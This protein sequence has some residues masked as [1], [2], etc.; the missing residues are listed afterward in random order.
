MLHH[1]PIRPAALAAL[2]LSAVPA[3]SSAGD[4]PDDTTIEQVVVIAHKDQRSIRDVA[5]NVTTLSRGELN[6]ELATSIGDAFRYVPGVDYEGAGTR[7]GTEGINIRGIGG[8]RVAILVDGVPLAD[9]FDTGSFSNATRDFIDAG[10]IQDIEVLHGPASAL[11]GSSAIGGVVAVRTPDPSDIARGGAFGGE[12]LGTWNGK[13]DSAHGQVMAAHGDDSFGFLAGYSRRS[14]EQTDS[15]A[16]PSDVDT[17][18]Y[19]RE[20]TLLKFVSDNR[21]GHTIRASAV[22]QDGHT[23]SNLNSVLGAGRYRSTTALEGD[24]HQRMDVVTLAYEFGSPESWIDSGVLRTFWQQTEI[25]QYTLDQRAA[26]RT[27]V[28]IDRRFSYDQEIRGIEMNLWKNITGEH[29]THRVGMG[30]E[31]RDRRTTEFRDGLST[32]LATGDQTNVLLGEVFPLR[33]FPISDTKQIAAFFEDTMSIGEKWTVIAAMRA[34]RYELSPHIDAMYLADYPDYETTHLD[35]SDISPKLGVIYSI[36]PRIDAYVQYSHGFRAPPYSDANVSLELPIFRVRAVPNPELESESSDGFDIGLRWYGLRSTA[37]V[38]AF[39]TNYTN[40]IET[41]VNIGI[42][43]VSG[44]TQFQ[45]QNIEDTT[46]E[47]IEAGW[48]VRFGDLEQ[49]MLDGSA[50]YARGDND[51]TGRPVNSVGPAQAVVGFSWFSPDETRELRLKSTLADAYD[52]VDESAGELFKPAGYAVFDL[53]FTQKLGDSLIVRA[54]LQNLTDRTYWTWTDVRGLAP[55]D[56]ILP[57]L[58]QAGRTA[59]VSLNLVW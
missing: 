37:R 52:R 23:L 54:G 16:S 35:E 33:D 48:N 15:A 11:Y 49:F 50:F 39:R 30:V 13:D 21:F 46:I 59:S 29:V 42:D 3:V 24:D 32:D 4:I 26:A 18:D 2:A 22:R 9:Q 7:F 57:Y 28:S 25:D 17:R 40:F 41:K 19:T 12:F 47:G 27:P 6:A 58:A 5:A 55:D 36:T 31:Y 51:G 38:S 43:P 45:S 20:T 14:G 53:Y 1:E 10:L 34:D 44:Y 56:P 8:N